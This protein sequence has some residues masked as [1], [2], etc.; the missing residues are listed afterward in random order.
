MSQRY[1]RRFLRYLFLATALF[2]INSSSAFAAAPVISEVQASS[3]GLHNAYVNATINPNGSTG[4]T[5][6]VEYGGTKLLEFST[7]SLSL[8]GT[9]NVPVRVELVG[10]RSRATYHFRVSATNSAGTT[11]SS[12]QEYENMNTWKVEG[13]PVLDNQ[14]PVTFEDEY[15][16]NEGEG[17][18]AEFRGATGGG[19][20]VRVYCRQSNEVFGA[21][22]I[23]YSGLEFKNACFTELN[24]VKSANC[25]PKNGITLYLNGLLAQYQPAVVEMGELC[26]IGESVTFSD[27]GFSPGGSG[28]STVYTNRFEGSTYAFGRSWEADFRARTA[29]QVGGWSLT[30]AYAGKAFGAS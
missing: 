20:Q 4:T 17:G 28:E 2:A 13:K 30:G 11:V 8:S 10:L 24:L 3:N 1:R 15:K 26:A 12:E 22:G 6:K 9:G 29:N 7:P 27:G 23:S 25:K 21:L 18:Y 14:A 5:Y 16:F 19:T